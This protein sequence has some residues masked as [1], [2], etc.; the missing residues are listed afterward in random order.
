MKRSLLAVAVAA[1]VVAAA[2]LA[3]VG[4]S[5]P[6]RG[7]TQPQSTVTAIGHADIS[8]VPDEATISAGV[9]SR[10][11]NARDAL[12]QNADLMNKV[13]AALER[14]G[15]TKLQTQ[16]VSLYPQ[17]DDHGNVTGFEAQDTV[18]AKA[19]I[20]SAGALIDA[21]VAAGANNV[22][23]PTLDVSDREALYRQAL[24]RAVEDARTK[25]AALGDAGGFTVGSVLSVTE[26]STLV[27]PQPLDRAAFAAAAATPT[28]IEPGTQDVTADVQVSFAIT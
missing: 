16:Q 14:A 17:T 25:A 26:Q 10:A 24:R 22:D 23:G 9:N 27:T 18:S 19:K 12:A 21:A 6:A 11:G 1:V 20:A 2:A 5:A 13:V 7:E 15:G 4:R 8:T 28:P 3:G